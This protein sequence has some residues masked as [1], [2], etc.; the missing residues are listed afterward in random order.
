MNTTAA[1]LRDPEG[2]YVIEEIELPP[3]GP[4]EL[5]VRVAGV[6]HCHSDSVIR[7]APVV[8]VPLVLGHEGS[9]VV[10]QVGP[11]VTGI[12]IG[13][14][15]VLTFDS[16]GTCRSCLTALPSYCDEFR[17]RNFMGHPR[18]GEPSAVDAAG[19][20]VGHRWFG[21]SSFAT[22]AIS[23]VR[24]TVVVDREVELD[25]LGPLGCG[26][27]TG[28]GSILN[29]LK[30]R[31]G[32]S[33][34]VFGVGAV[35]MAAVMAAR[36]AGAGQVIAVDRYHSRLDV[37]LSLGATH[38]L[39]AG[40]ELDL[41]GEIR[42]LTGGGADYTFDTTGVPAVIGSAVECLRMTGICG[43]VGVGKPVEI[44]PAALFGK[45]ILGIFEG[46]AV[47]QLLIPQLIEWWKAGLFP[48]DKLVER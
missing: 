35:G 21:Q 27:Q 1:V 13:D 24:N 11:G 47:A 44:N 31:P 38:V 36:I 10:E 40:A 25:L 26:M 17:A 41:L 22:H 23:T 48:F 28:A 42:A 9:G 12:S 34:V 18:D 20:P 7:H 29:A 6:G 19:L 3:P 15:V 39:Q 14:H 4:G 30:V 33:L 8:P 5:L 45:T 43:L 46:D 37:A 2:H 32:S 16:C